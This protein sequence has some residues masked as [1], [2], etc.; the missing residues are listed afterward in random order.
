MI[1]TQE[2]KK[3]FFHQRPY[4]VTPDSPVAR[5]TYDPTEEIEV[6]HPAAHPEPVVVPPAEQL[7]I[8]YNRKIT[9]IPVDKDRDNLKAPRIAFISIL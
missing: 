2:N 8:V 1:F 4:N 9:N 7:K 3:P 6:K 5:I